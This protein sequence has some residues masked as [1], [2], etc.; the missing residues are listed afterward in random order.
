MH[1]RA[2]RLSNVASELSPWAARALGFAFG[3]SGVIGFAPVAWYGFVVF[4]LAGVFWLWMGRAWADASVIGFAFGL[5][6]F[7]AGIHW[8]WYSAYAFGGTPLP[9]AILINLLLVAVLALYPAGFGW[10]A[11]RVFAMGRGSGLTLALATLWVLFESAR[12][13]LFTGFPWLNPGYA[14]VASPLAGYAP[15]GGVNLVALVVV[16]TAV[17]GAQVALGRIAFSGLMLPVA[18]WILG[19]AITQ[20]SWVTPQGKVLDTAIIQG[21]IDQTSKWRPE[22]RRQIVDRYLQMTGSNLDVDLIVWPETALPVFFDSAKPV[23]DDMDEDARERGVGLLIGAPTR[24]PDGRYFNSLVAMGAATG[25]YKKRH[26]VP[27]GEYVP[28]M[29][30]FGTLIQFLDVPMSNFSTGIALQT[31]FRLGDAAIAATICFEDAFPAVAHGHE[32][33]A[34]LMVNVSNDAWFGNTWAPD[35]HLQIARMRSLEAQRYQV[36][37]TNTGL[38]AVIDASG[39]IMD[40]GRPWEATVVRAKVPLMIGETPFIYVGT[41]VWGLFYVLIVVGFAVLFRFR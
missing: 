2:I 25:I 5:G 11:K 34:N 39:A 16:L 36:R 13:V 31:P 20:V 7:G 14:F 23:L 8:V 4:A 38:S 27:F 10:A 24:N 1:R 37:A 29:T 33:S 28:L 35:Q 19:W 6:W 26:L 32:G 41:G 40:I 12:G 15:I 18:L 22:Q 9:L 21:N 30:L 17:Q 3:V